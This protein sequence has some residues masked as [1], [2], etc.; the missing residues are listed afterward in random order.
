MGG[1]LLRDKTARFR[2]WASN[3]SA[4]E[5]IVDYPSAGEQTL[6]LAPELDTGNWSA[7]RFAGAAK[8]IY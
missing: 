6:S 7:D 5:V 2:V 8:P 1:L 3:A 4:V